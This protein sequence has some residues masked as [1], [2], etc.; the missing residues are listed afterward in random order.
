MCD[1]WKIKTYINTYLVKL[2]KNIDFRQIVKKKCLKHKTYRWTVV[3]REHWDDQTDKKNWEK[4]WKKK[5]MTTKQ[6]YA[7]RLF[8]KFGALA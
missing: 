8:E 4:K 5:Y 7:I 2:V 1:K 3:Q 6:M